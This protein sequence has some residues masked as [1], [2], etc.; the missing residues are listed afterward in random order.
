MLYSYVL[1][2]IQNQQRIQFS[3][4]S[5][6][7]ALSECAQEKE[8]GKNLC[9]ERRKKTLFR[10]SHARYYF[11]SLSL[12]LSLQYSTT[13]TVQLSPGQFFAASAFAASVQF[14]SCCRLREVPNNCR[15]ASVGIYVEVSAIIQSASEAQEEYSFYS[16]IENSFFSVTRSW[17]IIT[18]LSSSA[19][20]KVRRYHTY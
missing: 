15:R 20:R 16:G 10:L 1:R 12:S 19:L 8:L 13:H 11:F 3:L 14:W 4:C 2:L 9:R 18:V 5:V 17:R 6:L 7:Y